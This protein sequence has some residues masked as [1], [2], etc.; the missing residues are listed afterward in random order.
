MHKQRS[1]IT[2]ELQL[3]S[4]QYGA[5]SQFNPRLATIITA[6]KKQGFPKASIESAIARGQGRSPTGTALESL[7]IEAMVPPSVAIIVECQT[8]SKART[9]NDVKLA[10]KESGGTMTPTSHMFDRKGK[11][12]F[13]G[14]QGIGEEDIFD[15]AIEAG[16][17][18]VQMEEDSKVVVYA[19]S[20]HTTAV[21]D[22][23][24]TSSGL[25]VESLD[26]IWDPKED[27]MVDVA[28]SEMLD[29]FLGRYKAHVSTQSRLTFNF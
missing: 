18:D 2:K 20:S 11:I 19:E 12:V 25:K 5:D 8:D 9:L 13:V 22:A 7:T 4:K 24:A 10:I 1:A 23:L 27:M 15:Q 16:A 3:A 6:A 26:I 17:L 14:S 21:A 28:A 29:S